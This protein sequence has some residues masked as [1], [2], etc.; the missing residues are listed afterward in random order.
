[1]NWLWDLLSNHESV[2]YTVL[3][4]SFVIS[5]G[6]ALGRIKF[7]GISF[8]ITFVL[9]MGI[10]VSHFGYVINE[11]ILHFIKE[12]GL[13]LF[14][15]TIGLQVGPGF[16]SSF[17]KEGLTLNL[18]AI[19]IV[20][21]GGIVTVAIH[22]ISGTSI[23]TM[24][25]I[26]SGAVTNT[27]GLGAAQQTIKDLVVDHSEN[28]SIM[29]TL[30]TGY[31]IAYPFGVIGIIFTMLLMKK[32]FHVDIIAETRLNQL[33]HKTGS[34]LQ[35]IVVEVT[36][37]ALVGK[38]LRV[39]WKIMKFNFVVSRVKHD[40]GIFTPDK[41]YVLNEGDKLLIVSSAE[42]MEALESVIGKRIKIDLSS[43]GKK[44]NIISKKI[45]VTK[46]YAYSKR[47]GEL[48]IRD[49]Y[50]V[51]I[52]RVVRAGVEFIPDRNTKLQFG[53]TLV[54]IGEDAN[55]IALAKDFGNSKKQLGIPHIAELFLGIL[56]GVLVGS[57]PFQFP[58]IPVP[59]KL[60]L[61]GGPLIIAILISRYGGR[62]SVT[63]YVSSS[64]NLMVREI[65]IVLFLASV[66]LGAGDTFWKALTEGEGLYWML[67]GVFITLIPLIVGALVGRFFFRLNFL[68]I[69]GLMAGAS[70]DPPALAF[71]N[72]S[73]G[74][75]APAITYATVYPLTTFMRIMGAQLIL[76]LFF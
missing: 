38:E 58:G 11:H 54:V 26:M 69:C 24:V 13:I 73:A 2:A 15:Y 68:E 12:F 43:E 71:A 56:I 60:G 76:L 20:V 22:Y 46:S 67:Y 9:F 45:N 3:I 55:I 10:F 19:I 40:E 18:L 64:A 4:Y 44:Q 48:G 34:T 5:V 25:G 57:I 35:K 1:M 32:L 28:S 6:V 63:H 37:P 72:Q 39:L 33:K 49:K 74:S 30:S 59:V 52:S 8:G 21:T 16:F 36:N 17:K 7:F 31:A 41:K 42:D 66:G 62:I 50:G 27:P 70:T 65:G 61:A 47:L 14:V 51:T 53:D 75:D 29:Q 23:S